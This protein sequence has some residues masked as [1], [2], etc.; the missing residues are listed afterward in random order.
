VEPVYVVVRNVVVA[1]MRTWF[2]WAIEGAENIPTKG[3][4]ILAFNHISYLDPLAAAYVVDAAG[5]K[6]RFLAKSELF[7]DKRISWIL[8]GTRQI[9][10]KR[11]TPSAPLALEH[12]L[13]ALGRGELIA[14]FPEG[15]VTVDPDLRPMPA[16]TGAARMAIRSG[17]PL[18][19]CG[20]WGTSNILPREYKRYKVRWWPPKQDLL[21]RIGTPLDL[22]GRPDTPEVW[23]ATGAELMA[24]ISELTASLRPAVPDLR[25]PKA[26]SVA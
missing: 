5:R 3:P 4:A 17:A 19:P 20:L 13:E 16:K 10:V 18:I 24:G 15:K 7:D 23:R 21:V 8:R 11:G 6:P 1:S 9:E 22:S 12:A 2:R 25:S 26:R 14:I